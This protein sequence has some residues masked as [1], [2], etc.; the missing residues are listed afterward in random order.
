ME[1]IRI[2]YY[3]KTGNTKAVANFIAISLDK[4]ALEI[5]E[6]DYNS[7]CGLLFLGG[8]PYANIMS[9]HLKEYASNLKKENVKAVAL[10]TTSNWSRRTV[11]ALKKILNEKEIKVYDNYLYIHM[12]K[13]KSSKDKASIFAKEILEK[14]RKDFYG[15]DN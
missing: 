9:K 2:R 11:R 10:F 5:T 3:S 7:K 6:N 1:D 14:Y 15:K 12:L 4:E 8:A 13:V